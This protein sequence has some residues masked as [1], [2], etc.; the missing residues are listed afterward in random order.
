MLKFNSIAQNSI[1]L[2]N[3]FK[4]KSYFYFENFLPYSLEKQRHQ[5]N[6]FEVALSFR[7]M[8]KVLTISNVI[9]LRK[10]FIENKEKIGRSFDIYTGSSIMKF[11]LPHLENPSWKKVKNIILKSFSFQCLKNLEIMIESSI[12]DFVDSIKS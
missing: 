5:N 10:I 11:I 9:I 8:K 7:F 6:K 12:L 1:W 2:K 3:G 4:I